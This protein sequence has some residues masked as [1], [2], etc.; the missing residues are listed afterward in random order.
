MFTT[1]LQSETQ[2][3]AARDELTQAEHFNWMLR[4]TVNVVWNHF[5]IQSAC[6]LSGRFGRLDVC[7][8]NAGI[9]G[10]KAPLHEYSTDVFDQVLLSMRIVRNTW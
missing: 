8:N 6:F 1:C 10:I 2:S 5:V 3:L 4:R 7:L 9:E